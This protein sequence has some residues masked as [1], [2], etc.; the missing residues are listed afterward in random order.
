MYSSRKWIW[1]DLISIW[2]ELDKSVEA[3]VRDLFDGRRAPADGLDGGGHTGTVVACDVRLELAKNNPI[4]ENQW[5]LWNVSQQQN[6][7]VC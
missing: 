2:Q 3:G 5:N 6:Q 7:N 1:T 4:Q